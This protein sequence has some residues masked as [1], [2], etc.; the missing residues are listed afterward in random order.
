MDNITK[1]KYLFADDYNP[2]HVNGAYGG[3]GTDNEIVIHFYHERLPIPK[4]ADIT[5][6]ES[7]ITEV[8]NTG[9]TDIVRFIQSGVVMSYNTA[10]S[11]HSWLGNLLSNVEGSSDAGDL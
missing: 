5:I 2:G 11:I 6:G 3:L 9:D 1:V 8:F 7:S 10:K 4:S